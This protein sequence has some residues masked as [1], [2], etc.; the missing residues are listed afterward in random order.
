MDDERDILAHLKIGQ[1][2]IQKGAMFAKAVFVG[3]AVMQLFGI[4]HADQIGGNQAT[5]PFQMRHDIAP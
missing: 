5:L 3:S 4:A 1:Q 2:I